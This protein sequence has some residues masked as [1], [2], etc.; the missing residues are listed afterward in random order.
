MVDVCPLNNK[1]PHP[2]VASIRN[3]ISDSVCGGLYVVDSG[4]QWCDG[5][6]NEVGKKVIVLNI[7]ENA[8]TLEYLIIIRLD[9]MLLF[10]FWRKVGDATNANPTNIAIPSTI[11]AINS[12]V[13]LSGNILKPKSQRTS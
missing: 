2:E 5:D 6:G 13:S 7:I 8:N 9:V 1:S 10:G 4:R 11:S 3:R 12:V